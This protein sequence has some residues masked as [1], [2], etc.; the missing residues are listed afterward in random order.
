MKV[1]LSYFMSHII[2]PPAVYD[3]Q[4]GLGLGL[5][6]IYLELREEAQ[7]TTG[8]QSIHVYTEMQDKFRSSMNYSVRQVS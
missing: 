2:P 3:R 6:L 4:T 1:Q 7:I 5:G 8:G